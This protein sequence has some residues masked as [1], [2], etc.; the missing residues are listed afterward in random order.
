LR[1]TTVAPTDGKVRFDGA[2]GT[3]GVKRY[4]VPAGIASNWVLLAVA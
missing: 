1:V 3:F 4:A 2:V